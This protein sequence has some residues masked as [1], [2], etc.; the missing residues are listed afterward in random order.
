M[1]EKDKV[2][3]KDLRIFSFG[4]ANGTPIRV[5]VVNDT[6]WFVARDVCKALG[7]GWRGDTLA[8]I[9]DD[10]K[11]LRSF[12]T[13]GGDQQ[14]TT[15]SE[16]GLYKLVFRCNSSAKA[17]RFTNWVASEVLPSIRRSGFYGTCDKLE[18]PAP[19]RGTRERRIE[20]RRRSKALMLFF[21]E[22][23]TWT[24]HAD[25][26]EIA[27]QFGV[28]AEHVRRVAR[29]TRPGLDVTSALVT[30][31]MRNRERGIMREPVVSRSRYEVWAEGMCRLINKFM[32]LDGEEG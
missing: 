31:A 20:P 13:P 25:D 21:D 30:R 6:F 27:R 10:W 8:N 23:S 16:P 24:T 26:A 1:S 19:L 7:I 18:M 9:P 32:P 4:E 17:D 12:R 5:H 3:V 15:L 28:S 22:L 14:L 2:Q 11:G 29:G